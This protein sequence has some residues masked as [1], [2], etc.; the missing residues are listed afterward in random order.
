MGCESGV[1]AELDVEDGGTVEE[2]E[3]EVDKELDEGPLGCFGDELSS[4]AAPMM[5]ATTTTVPSASKRCDF[6]G[7]LKFQ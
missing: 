2:S 6:I 7:H 5:R 4:T 3:D 1:V